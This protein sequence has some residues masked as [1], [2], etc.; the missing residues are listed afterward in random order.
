MKAHFQPLSLLF[1]F[2]LG[3]CST[4]SPTAAHLD[5]HGQKSEAIS[6]YTCPMHPSVK[7]KDPGICPICK[8]DL[9][10]VTVQQM[11]TGEVV[12]EEGHRQRI[13]VRTAVVERRPLH[14]PFRAL[15]E[16]HWD[17]ARVKDITARVEGWVESLNASR[18]GD[19]IGKGT[20]LLTLYSPALY[21]TQQE[22]LNAPEGSRLAK[23][24][25]ERLRLWGLSARTIE[26]ILSRQKALQNVPIHAPNSGVLLEKAV[27]EG[28]HVKAGD[29]LFRVADSQ[30][31]WVEAE[32]FEQDLADLTEGQQVQISL[33]HGSNAP[34]EG[35]IDRIY[36]NLDSTS[37]TGRIRITVP[38]PDGTLRP[39][40]LAEVEM[41][42]DLGE[43]LTVSPDAVVHTGPRKVVYVDRGQGRLAPVEVTIGASTPEWTVIESG[44]KEGDTIVSSGVFLIAA[45]SRI[46]STPNDEE[47]SH[48]GH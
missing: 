35:R 27:N 22:L 44:L 17:E 45:E 39:G 1:L 37:R 16:V 10:A 36:P 13:G 28:A 29:L 40:M 43:A 7:E 19:L 33:T 47:V 34:I 26:G 11:T 31:V 23:N 18:T 38:N 32:V 20:V 30:K 46:R 4:T 14:R 5:E 21:S 2:L 6:H 48:A 25:K 15:G 41:K 9:T 12:V 24:S 8:M 3:G 42:I